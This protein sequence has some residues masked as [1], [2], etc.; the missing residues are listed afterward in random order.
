MAKKKKTSSTWLRQEINTKLS[1]VF[2]LLFFLLCVLIAYTYSVPSVGI[3][4]ESQIQTNFQ[5]F[6]QSLTPAPK[7]IKPIH[8]KVV[9]TPLPN[10]TQIALM[11][12]RGHIGYPEIPASP[13]PYEQLPNQNFDL[14]RIYQTGSS[15]GA[16]ANNVKVIT[17]I[18]TINQIY[19]D[20]KSLPIM[21]PG[22]Y[23]C[24][25]EF[26]N[27]LQYSLNFYSKGTFT[28]NALVQ[29]SGCREV[30]ISPHYKTRMAVGPE[31][32]KLFEDLQKI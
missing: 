4:V 25:A 31:G 16:T 14:L 23:N 29:T 6:I 9:E 5:N 3:P 22:T 17:N 18:T 10:P 12:S 8:I 24:P 15:L 30:G 26:A 19:N 13:P 2:I 21:L 1:Y 20:I 11:R 32:E 28:I 27:A 7:E